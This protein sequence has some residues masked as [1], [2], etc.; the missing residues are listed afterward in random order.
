[1]KLL[2]NH[3][4]KPLFVL[5]ML[6]M[7]SCGSMQNTEDD[8]VKDAREAREEMKQTYPN[9][10][11]F[12]ENSAGY[13]IFPNVGKGAYIIGAASG[14]GVVYKNDA[15]IGYS[16]LKQLDVGLQAGG[17]AFV[18]VLFFETEADLEEFKE[19]DYE[20]SANASA[21]VLEEG[22]SSSINFEEGVAI[23]T[24]PKAGAMAGVSVGGQRFTFQPVQ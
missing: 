11:E 14:D 23:V 9:A 16:D 2:T 24:M 1:M 7:S 19:N 13:A 15:V 18:E 3:F 22:V 20:L 5:T 12:F 6:I 8:L 17:K 4:Y 21:V 10:A